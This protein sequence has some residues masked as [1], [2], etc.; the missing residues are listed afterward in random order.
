MK[1]TKKRKQGTYGSEHPVGDVGRFM[2][3]LDG[4]VFAVVGRMING[5]E[6]TAA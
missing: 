1:P 2:E 5:A 4:D 6:A 3:S